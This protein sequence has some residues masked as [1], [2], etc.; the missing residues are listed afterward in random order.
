[1]EVSFK[2]L[3]HLNGSLKFTI[4]NFL[5]IAGDYAVNKEMTKE[6]HDK[7][8]HAKQMFEK[9]Y[10][11][12]KDV[13]ERMKIKIKELNN[14]N[15]DKFEVLDIQK[16]DKFHHIK[17]FVLINFDMNFKGA[18]PNSDEYIYTLYFYAVYEFLFNT[19]NYWTQKITMPLF[20]D[21]RYFV[22][23]SFNEV[24]CTTYTLATENMLDVESR[25]WLQDLKI[26]S[27]EY[28]LY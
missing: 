12:R 9:Y 20:I 24:S 18:F 15:K 22:Y 26:K 16:I 28:S 4:H 10:T 23:I 19:E 8:E 5:S 17:S 14:D 21:N 13:I 27:H 11:L 2:R 3:K 6:I 1:M 7:I 25:V